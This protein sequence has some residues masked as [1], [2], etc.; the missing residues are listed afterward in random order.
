MNLPL[1]ACLAATPAPEADFFAQFTSAPSAT[2]PA[3][4]EIL[5]AIIFSFLLNALVAWTYKRTY[6]GTRYS[7]DYVHTSAPSSAS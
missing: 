1:H 7:Q 5:F 4:T 2:P 6:R 3:A